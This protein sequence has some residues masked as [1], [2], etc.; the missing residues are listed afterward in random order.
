MSWLITKTCDQI[1][2]GGGACDTCGG[3]AK[4]MQ[5]FGGETRDHVEYIG[6]SETM[7]RKSALKKIEREGLDWVH[8][9]QEEWCAVMNAVVNP[10][11][12]ISCGEFFDHLRNRWLP[13]KDCF[14]EFV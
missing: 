5:G 11:G 12:S 8:K 7:I 3:E 14:M 13:K 10:S 9:A 6:V 1:E 4:C 2:D